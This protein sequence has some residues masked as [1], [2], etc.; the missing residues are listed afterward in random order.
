MGNWCQECGNRNV[1]LYKHEDT[2]EVRCIDCILA[3][4]E[5]IEEEGAE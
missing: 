1:D 5:H 2:N 3:N 4:W